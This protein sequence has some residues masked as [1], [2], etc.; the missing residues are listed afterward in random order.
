MSDVAVNQR[1][2]PRKPFTRA[3]IKVSAYERVASWLLAALTLLGAVTLILLMIWIGSKVTVTPVAVPVTM[4]NIEDVGGG[5]ENGVFGQDI[6]IEGPVTGELGSGAEA[7]EETIQ[8]TL[9]IVTGVVAAQ[10]PLL[11]D[12]S[13]REPFSTGGIGGS[14]GTGTAPSLGEGGGSG[15]GVKR[16]LRWIIDYAQAS[17]LEIYAA[18]LDQFQIELG[19]LSIEGGGQVSYASRF[20]GVPQ[21]REGPKDG[22]KRLYFSWKDGDLQQAD[23]QLL[24]RAGVDSTGKAILQ[25]Y[26]EATEQYLARIELDYLNT[27][28]PPNRRDMR[29]VKRTRF[30]VRGGQGA[31]FEFFVKTQTYLGSL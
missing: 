30:G 27:V 25:F 12:I 22:E 23:R 29:L 15:G 2:A 13:E 10:Q 3:E 21:R 5:F 14:R 4:E 19:A 26:P 11:D 24:T 16:H 9:E 28:A 31:P 8:Q 6:E 20:T 18:Q 17:S 7:S 1:I